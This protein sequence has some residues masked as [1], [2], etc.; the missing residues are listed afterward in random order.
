MLIAADKMQKIALRAKNDV[1]RPI[2]SFKTTIFLCGS[3]KRNGASIRDKI[4]IELQNVWNAYRYDVFY[5]EDLFE[6]VLA[7]PR[8]I[9]LLKLENLLADSVDLI[10]LIPESPGSISELGAF[11]NIPKFVSKIVCVQDVKYRRE[12]S[13]INQGPIKLLRERKKDQIVYVDYNYLN[14][15]DVRKIQSSIS[16]NRQDAEK[17]VGISN[18]IQAENFIVICIYLLESAERQNLIQAVGYAVETD[19]HTATA[20]ATAAIAQLAKNQM[21]IKTPSGYCL[22]KLGIQHFLDF[23][24]R[25]KSKYNY[26]LKM[27]DKIRIDLLTWQYRKKNLFVH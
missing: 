20:I 27:M 13:F 10:L 9:N 15:E 8:S 5:P 26:D 18:I 12:K 16:K 21:I 3:G 17:K 22:T 7:G 25:G 23:G 19:E 6:E 4:G 14:P 11:V 1:F 2:Y 24:R